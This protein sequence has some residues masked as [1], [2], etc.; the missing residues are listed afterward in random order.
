VVVVLCY[1]LFFPSSVLVC[2][3][4]VV[5]LLCSAVGFF[6][7][8]FC[9]FCVLRRLVV[10]FFC[11]CPGVVGR[12]SV[13]GLVGCGWRCRRIFSC[14]RLMVGCLLVCFF[15]RESA[16]SSVSLCC[17]AVLGLHEINLGGC[18]CAVFICL[19]RS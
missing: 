15:V 8:S 18:V 4:L 17:A 13:F 19:V 5:S 1:C 9:W 3:L 16:I 11:L 14:G 10:L 12:P 6:R 7:P 2:C